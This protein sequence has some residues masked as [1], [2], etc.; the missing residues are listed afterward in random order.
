[1]EF[2]LLLALIIASLNLEIELFFETN[3]I[4]MP[5]ELL[6]IKSCPPILCAITKLENET[7][8]INVVAVP[9]L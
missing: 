7:A 8:S 1:M 6:I 9:S 4:N 3:G 5:V 2:I